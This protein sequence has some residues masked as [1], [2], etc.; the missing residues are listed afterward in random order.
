MAIT[1]RMQRINEEV[2]REISTL[3][4]E[5]KDPRIGELVSVIAAEVTKDMRHAKIFVSVLG[6]D[7][8]KKDTVEGLKSADSFLRRELGARVGLRN[9]P[10]LDIRLDNTI[11]RGVHIN[12]ILRDLNLN[13][14]T[15][16]G[17]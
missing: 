1:N 11:E 17:E 7:K 10:R 9:T 3:I 6:D 8:V 4:R 14:H 13:D 15:R 2:K 12:N 16:Q 5:L